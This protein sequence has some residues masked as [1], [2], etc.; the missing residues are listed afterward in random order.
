MVRQD[1]AKHFADFAHYSDEK[2]II[3][4]AA[5]D[6]F[7]PAQTDTLLDVGAGNGELT[8]LLAP[9]FQSVECIEKNPEH[10]ALL[11]RKYA[12]Y[13][14][15]IDS[16]QGKKYDATLA[17]HML[18]SIKEPQRVEFVSQLVSHARKTAI[19]CFGLE[20]G[21]WYELFLKFY[22]KERRAKY[23]NPRSLA[24][25]LSKKYTVNTIDLNSTFLMPLETAIPVFSFFCRI[26][27]EREKELEEHLRSLTQEGTMKMSAHH[28]MIMIEN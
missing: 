26:K 16:Y 22:E 24:E 8:D 11:R 18:Y 19:V 27:P 3:A 7:R 20:L 10:V 28:V 6:F 25:N 9:H 21:G 14:A 13:E 5:L 12:V 1:Y 17:S 4:Q 23:G 15:A 2:R